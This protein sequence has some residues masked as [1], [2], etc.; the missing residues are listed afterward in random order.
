MKTLVKNLLKKNP[1]M[2]DSAKRLQTFFAKKDAAWQF[3]DTFSKVHGNKV[4]FLYIGANDGMRS[5][6]IRYFIVRDR[7]SGILVEPLPNV[8]SMLKSNFGYLNKLKLVFVNAA[9]SSGTG[10][11]LSFWTY[12]ER[13]LDTLSMEAR[14]NCLRK[15]SFDRAHVLRWLHE[16]KISEEV[17]KEIKVPSLSLSELIKNQWNGEPINLLVMDAE[18]HEASIIPSIDFNVL[19]P[20]AIYFESHNLGVKKSDVYSFLSRNGYE[21]IEI[22]GDSIALLKA[23]NLAWRP[24]LVNYIGAATH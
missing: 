16:D 14:I 21:I 10:S 13:Y 2:F 24:T 3:F 6:P 22:G 7:W 23:A 19:K 15:S 4:S 20:E 18:G 11:D 8:F 17:L 5:D 1:R 9:I 12:D